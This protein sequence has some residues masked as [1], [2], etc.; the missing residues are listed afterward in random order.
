MVQCLQLGGLNFHSNDGALKM[1]N[2]HEFRSAR[3]APELL[4]QASTQND[5]NG[6]FHETRNIR[7]S[8]SQASTN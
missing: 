5:V 1:A 6:G 4:E 2:F 7:E 8:K 3:L